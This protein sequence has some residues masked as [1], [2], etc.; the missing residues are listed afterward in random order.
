MKKKTDFT[1]QGEEVI[2]YFI[3][4]AC[5]NTMGILYKLKTITKR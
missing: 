4:C 1:T 3:L 2:L 5:S